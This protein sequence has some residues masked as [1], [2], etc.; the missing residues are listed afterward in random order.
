[1]RR[2]LLA[3]CLLLLAIVV[4]P[5]SARAD[6]TVAKT[7]FTA[8]KKLYDDGKYPEAL[9]LFQLAW[10]Y[11]HSPN[12][13]LY[14]AKCFLKL[15]NAIAA[16][17]EF[18]GTIRDAGEKIASD[19]DYQLAQNAA[20]AELVLLEPR[21][22]KLVVTLDATGVEGA[23]VTLNGEAFATVNL[24]ETVTV[25]PGKY[26]IVAK[27]K[28]RDPITRSETVE[29]GKTV[30]VA[31]SFPQ[32]VG[33]PPPRPIEKPVEADAGLST[34]QIVG[35]AT[36]GL[37]VGSLLAAGATGVAA[38]S[39]FDTL[40]DACGDVPCD[41][42]FND[43]IDSGETL[44]LVSFILLGAGGALVIGGGAMWIFGGD[45]TTEPAAAAT[46][47]PLPGGAAFTATGSF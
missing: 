9:Q 23:E 31:L 20:A 25:A 13:R 32:Q 39:K 47:V 1:M 4:M 27:A 22:G 7:Q 12:A 44:E 5:A 8:A 43:T 46:L 29:G 6:D 26:E 14:V 34:L 38:K 42:R 19:P 18:R 24:G 2:A 35:I 28:G 11:S 17:D 15:D 36:L 10:D 16:Y 3:L 33:A 21:I 45:D 40:E 37:G 41:A 30:S